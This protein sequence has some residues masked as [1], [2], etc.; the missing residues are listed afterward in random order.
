MQ[1]KLLHQTR[2]KLAGW[3]ASVMGLILSLCGLVVY[4]VLISAYLFSIDREL[5]AVTGTLHNSIERDLKRAN[6]LEP[7]VQQLLPDICLTDTFCETRPAI[8]HDHK[9]STDPHIVSNIYQGNYYIRF[10]NTLGKPIASSGVRPKGLLIILNATTWQTLSD[11]QG[12]RYHQMSLPL[13]T[14]S[15]QLWGYLQVGRSLKD[16]DERLAALKI[17]FFLGLPVI[18]TLVGGSSWLLAGLA[19][20]PINRSY[21]QMQWFTSDAAHELRSPLAAILA[22]VESVL[23]LPALPEREARDTLKTIERQVYRLFELSKDLL[24]LSRL[25]QHTLIIQLQPLC[26]N[27]LVADLIEEFSALATSANLK[28]SAEVKTHQPVHILADEDQIYRLTSN[29]IMNAIQYTSAGGYV[30]LTLD[31]N[32]HYALLQIRDTGIGI[33]PENQSR[34]FDRF[35]R[36]SNDRSRQTGGAGLGLSIAQAIAQAHK[37]NIQLKSE[38]G[39]GSTFITQLPLRKITPKQG[40]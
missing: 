31:C 2:L 37:G 25:E 22:T 35:Y 17:T 1:T 38:V 29:L 11:H 8:N 14:T 20:R 30:T 7:T 9:T 34:I 6:Q 3:Y 5:E 24:L 15:D 21:E 13:H 18:V 16:L 33:S 36:V 26:L 28:L 27:D 39:R 10:L 40:V 23:R 19:M 4:E 32:D 12:N